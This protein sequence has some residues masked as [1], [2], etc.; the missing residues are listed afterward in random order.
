MDALKVHDSIIKDYTSY[1]KSF[2]NIADNEIEAIVRDAIDSGKL[3]PPPLLQFNP[4]FERSG[5]IEQLVTDGILVP[6]ISNVFTGYELYTHQ[7]EAI[8]L[9]SQGKDFVVTSGTG[10]GK[11][12]TY[13][14]T[15]FNHL[16]SNAGEGI[17]A[18]IV[19]PMNALINSQSN[20]IS[21]YAENYL[22]ATGCDFPITFGQYT[23]QESKEQRL[24]MCQS[25][26][27]I[28]LTNYMMLELILTR[29][30]SSDAPGEEVIR[31]SIYENLQFLVFDELHT[32]RGRQG[33]DV[34]MLIRRIRHRCSNA[35]CSIGTSATM[36]SG[37]TVDDQR[38]QV[39]KVASDLFGTSINYTQVIYE[40]LARSFAGASGGAVPE[41]ELKSSVLTPV[42]QAADATVLKA[43]PTAVWLENIV[44]L[45]E[46]EDGLLLRNKPLQFKEVIEQL[47]KDSGCDNATC[48]QHLSE[49]L[50]WIGTV[51][52][53]ETAKGSRYTFLPYKL[54]Q[55]IS[56]TGAVYTTLDQGSERVV[57]LDPARTTGSEQK[58]LYPNVFSRL[59]GERFL[60]VFLNPGESKLTRREFR[61]MPDEE[62]QLNRRPGYIIPDMDCWDPENDMELLPSSWLKASGGAVARYA[63]RLPVRI[64]FDDFGNYSESSSLTYEGWFM[65]APLLFDPTSG[66]FFTGQTKEGTKLT[67]LGTEGRSTSTTITT[68]SVL[69]HL[70][71][72]GF[73]LPDQKLLSFTDNR[74]DAALQTGHFNDFIRVVQLRC[75]LYRALLNAG[76]SPLNY[77]RLGKAMFDALGMETDV[78]F[79]EFANMTSIPGFP[80]VRV[81]YE[82]TLRKYLVYRALYDLRRGWRVILPNLEQTGLLRIQY[83]NLDI[84]AE[85]ESEWENVPLFGEVGLDVRKELI[86][87]TLEYFRLEYALYNLTYLEDQQIVQNERE[88]REKLADP[89]KFDRDEQ[90]HR[91]RFVR[92]ETLASFVT[93]DTASAGAMSSLGRYFITEAQKY[94]IDLRGENYLPFIS[95]LLEKLENAGYLF[96]DT[97]KTR[98]NQDTFIYQLKLDQ[99]LWTLGD[100]TTVPV[101]AVKQRTYKKIK[102]KPNLFFQEIYKLDMLSGKRLKAEDHTG[103]LNHDQR[104]DREGKFRE[105]EIS[106]LYCSPTMELGID[107]SNLSVVHMRN[108]P[109]NAANYAQRSGRAGRSGQAA[110]VFTYCSTFSNHDQHYFKSQRELVAGSVMPP[111]LDLCNEELLRTHLHAI[112]LAFIQYPQMNR[113]LFELVEDTHELNLKDEVK[114]KFTLDDA[115]LAKVKNLFVQ[116]ISTFEAEL[117]KESHWFTDQW[118]SIEL[119]NLVSRLD[120]SL[121][122]WRSMYHSAL[123]MLQ[124]A[125]QVI[126]SNLH[127]AGSDKYKAAERDQFQANR[128]LDLL[129]NRQDTRSSQLSEF[130]PFRYFASETFL[131]GYNFPR[132]PLRVFVSEG[133]TGDF[134]SRPRTIAL[135]EFGPHNLLYYNGRKYEVVQLSKQDLESSLTKAKVSLRSGYF[136]EKNELTLSNCPM[137]NVDLGQGTGNCEH[138]N[139]LVEMGESRAIPR[140]RISC[141]EEERVARGYQL[142]SYFNVPGGVS[143][144]KQGMIKSDEENFLSIRFMPAARLVYVNRRWRSS[145][146]QGFPMGMVTGNWKNQRQ[147]EE[148]DGNPDAEEIRMVKPYTWDT[149]DA[150]YLEPVAALG[151]DADGIITLQYALKRAIENLFQIEPRELGVTALGQ[152]GMP[153]ILLYEASEG[154]L[155]VLSQF[156]DSPDIFAKVVEHAI[157]VCRYEED[158]Y[159]EAAS[160][161]DLLSYFNQRDHERID[162]FLIKDAL[163]KLKTCSIELISNQDLGDYDAHYKKILATIDPSSSTEKNFLDYLYKNNL[164]LPD[165]AQHSPKEVYVRPD[166]FYKPNVYVFCDGTPHDRPD[167]QEDD[168]RKRA[169]L[170]DEGYDVVV[171]YYKDDLDDLIANRPDIFNKVR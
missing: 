14:G 69:K 123:N 56:Q 19:Y 134:I 41:A 157:E 42:D 33:A 102:S 55:F 170:R 22:K 75:G 23:G 131:P 136:M 71:E 96:R 26:P 4:S 150:L 73:D 51:N 85:A 5:P 38:K 114:E 52:E 39:A 127:A 32:Y 1:I 103:Q 132:L 117:L 37:G 163:E 149:A 24:A 168:K 72:A 147:V 44:A 90:I 30:G 93:S 112:A 88:I 66:T 151:L 109:P 130:Y 15:I 92:Y 107:I 11:S 94:D 125:T 106:A 97:A 153:N 60:C 74:Q 120:Q 141:E 50:T 105:G 169:A 10:S 108:V 161:D 121:A 70:A 61:E 25:P 160:Y 27:D 156:M 122:R 119:N 144:I 53:V 68:F 59:S 57:T 65:P 99:V 80:N 129:K 116:V 126:N 13:L 98:D 12:L 3:W 124:Q 158:G 137:T 16:F 86:F 40:K 164:C 77:N 167:V 78:R 154:G 20:E 28:L 84:I 162:R 145:N 8:K 111:K 76:S 118:T 104:V 148:S 6:D 43:H 82:E 79:L 133:K 7:V 67:S 100:E 101:D 165:S 95:A 49:I 159:N 171:Y 63:K 152:T 91:P 34:G 115:T 83:E 45:R 81:Q 47:E 146:S 62:E 113:S 166:F 142:E 18:V 29:S 110:L 138:L 31:N 140:D 21:T 139:D 17:R 54:H 89:W 46:N 2:I 64:Y 9:G 36:V 128:Q 87:N 155:G 135:R 58:P 48:E 35:I 143:R